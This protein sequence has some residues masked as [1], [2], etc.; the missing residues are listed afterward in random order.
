L[1]YE[2]VCKYVAPVESAPHPTGG[3]IVLTLIDNNGNELEMGTE[4]N[5]EPVETNYATYFN[6]ENISAEAKKNRI[7]L[8]NALE[9][10]GFVNY[11]TEWWHW[12]Y[13]DKYW[14]YCLKN[15]C[16]IY[17]WSDRRCK[18]RGLK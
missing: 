9:R 8:K 6:A 3:A 11:F 10:V 7:I 14:A 16:A 18:Y 5:A 15:N 4:F 17:V 13:G 12:S 2:E 1:V